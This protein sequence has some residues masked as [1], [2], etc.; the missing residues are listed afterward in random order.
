MIQS[1]LVD[2]VCS[3]IKDVESI[4]DLRVISETVKRR[5]NYLGFE[6]GSN[7]QSGDKV[8]VSNGRGKVDKGTVIKINRTKA[9]IDM[10][11]G[12]WNVPFS[13]ITKETED[14][15]RV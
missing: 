8:S 11:G 7:L 12:S 6:V 9:V 1:E 4:N 15:K 14:E 3:Y 2:K 13:M 10:R 5:R